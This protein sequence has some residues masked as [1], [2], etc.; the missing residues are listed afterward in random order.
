MI[1]SNDYSGRRVLVTGHTGFKG[2][3][4]SSWLLH[5]G[6]ELCGLSLDIPSTPSNFEV[7]G[8]EKR[9]RHHLC[10]VRDIRR[11]AEIIKEF[12]PEIVFHLAAQPLVR[13][14]YAD[15]LTTFTTN[16]IGTLN[17]LEC[18]R[19]EESIRA[20]VI[21]TSDKCYR[22]SEWI[23]GY[24]ENDILGGED[25]YSA[26]KGCAEL[27]AFSYMNSY[28]KLQTNGPLVATARAGNVIGGGDWAEDRI[29]PD[30]MKSWAKGTT[31]S[32]RNP[33]STRPW[34]HVMEPLSGYLKLGSELWKR[35]PGISGSSYNF[36][37]DATVNHSVV[38]LIKALSSYWPNAKYSIE[39]QVRSDKPEA[40]L[41]KL[42][43]DKALA[44]LKWS[45][46]L[47]FQ[48]TVKLTGDWYHQFL[49]F[50]G[51]DMND[52]TM[53]QIEAYCTCARNKDLGWAGDE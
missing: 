8:L 28:F 31:V 44:E 30:C 26:S 32:V 46:V 40:Q 4:L 7:L 38:T 3:W 36:G 47:S 11:M 43:C 53:K 12:R 17:V 19:H 9:M 5:L 13:R 39:P 23:W 1:F 42:C 15:P 45:A 10:D 25:P 41:L 37:P 16:T 52:F 27:V 51:T 6:A 20:A 22:N 18:I 21:V 48:E 35:S 33:K 29:V 50:P 34:Q 2:S 49:T 24:R 14:S